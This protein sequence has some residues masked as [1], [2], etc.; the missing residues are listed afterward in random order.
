MG[1]TKEEIREIVENLGYRL[2]DE[3]LYKNYRKVIIQ[4]SD[5]YKY[6]CHLYYLIKHHFQY[7]VDTRNPFT[8]SHNIP[9][10]L[11]KENKNFILCENNV[12][13]NF[14]EKLFFRC[15]RE[16][17]GEI[18]DCSWNN[19]YSKNS[20][21]PY[22]S[23]RRVGKYNNLEYLRPDL[24][25]EWDYEKNNKSPINYTSGSE[26]SVFWICKECQHGWKTK[27]YKRVSGTGCPNCSIKK[28]ESKIANKLKKYFED[29]YG[30]TS[31]YR[32]IKNPKTNQWLRCDIY[33]PKENVYIEVHGEQHYKINAWHK[34]RAK[35]NG[36]T[37]EE[38]FKYQKYKDRL[39]KKFAKKNGVY[40]EI[41]LMKIKTVEE[42]IEYIENKIKKEK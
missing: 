9:L 28:H 11:K 5:G 41:N 26:E 15:T 30:S 33:L 36:T 19:L 31:E 39:K 25:R 37:P 1:R 4:D 13:K 38:E 12:Y 7:F 6:D 18:F 22:C 20:E 8:L 24:S 10:W 21:C 34:R 3:Y 29:F 27:I 2:L 23:G 42:A 32:L 40:I 35:K 17:C 14:Y 16:S